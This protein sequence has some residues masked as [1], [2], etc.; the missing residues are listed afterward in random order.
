MGLEQADQLLGR[1]HR[2]A[3]QN[4]PLSLCDDLLDQGPIVADLSLPEHDREVAR[5]GQL[6]RGLVQVG[7]GDPGELDQLAVQLHPFGPPAG[8]LDVPGALLRRPPV[9]APCE[10][11]AANPR[12]RLP[13]QAHHYPDRVP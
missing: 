5:G 12:L 10:R 13:Q 3:G 11:A 2:L 8:V 7:Q 4:P 9:I 1:R 6:Q